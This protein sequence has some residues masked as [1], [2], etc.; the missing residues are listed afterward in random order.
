MT[1]ESEFKVYVNLLQQNEPRREKTRLLCFRP[2][3][4]ATE[5]GLKLEISDLGRKEILLSIRVAK[6]KAQ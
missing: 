5:D 1:E 3:C 6:T 4:R 2:G